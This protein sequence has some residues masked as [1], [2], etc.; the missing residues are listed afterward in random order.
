MI[1]ADRL[2]LREFE[3]ADW[4]AVYQWCTDPEVRRF[5]LAGGAWTQEQS[6]AYVQQAIACAQEQPRMTYASAIVLHTDGSVIG[7]CRLSVVSS[8]PREGVIGFGFARQY[9]GQ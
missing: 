4:Q 5:R 2:F 3:P 6:R 8:E 9:W 1:F 7:G